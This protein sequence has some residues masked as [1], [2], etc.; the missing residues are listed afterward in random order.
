MFSD[1]LWI[2][3]A[4]A[5]LGLLAGLCTWTRRD[6]SAR[7]PDIERVALHGDALRHHTFHLWAKQ[8]L[9]ADASGFQ[10]DTYVGP[11]RIATATPPPVGAFV[12]I[13][14]RPT[15][16]RTLEAVNLNV[17]SGYV[18]KR[19]ANYALSVLTVLAYLW[20]IRRRFR[21]RIHEG[22]F[23]GRY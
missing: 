9:A 18:W 21:W 12:S 6:L 20:I 19:T 16:P 23:R 3:K 7:H 13:A 4:A 14:A 17:H 10:V 5:A 15:G 1:R 2:L 8:V 11:M 22:V